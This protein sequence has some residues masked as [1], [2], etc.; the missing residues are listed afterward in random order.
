MGN[1]AQKTSTLFSKYWWVSVLHTAAKLHSSG[2]RINYY[3]IVTNKQTISDHGYNE[4]D[5]EEILPSVT[6]Q[7]IFVLK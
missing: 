5:S 3:L 7:H 1:K 6:E 4:S 2:G